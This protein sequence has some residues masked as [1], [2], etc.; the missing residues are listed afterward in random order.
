MVRMAASP[1]LIALFHLRLVFEVEPSI[2]AMKSFVT[3]IPSSLFLAGS[4]GTMF[5]SMM[6]IFRG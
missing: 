2:T 5:C 1:L 3:T 4:F 6:F